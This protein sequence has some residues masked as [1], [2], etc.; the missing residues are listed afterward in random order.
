M[1][2]YCILYF[3][4]SVTC[5]RKAES[6]TSGLKLQKILSL[7]SKKKM[8]ETIKEELLNSLKESEDEDEASLDEAIRNLKDSNDAIKD[9]RSY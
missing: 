7:A 4:S 6:Y 3:L 9:M 2:D 1:H 8:V 5:K